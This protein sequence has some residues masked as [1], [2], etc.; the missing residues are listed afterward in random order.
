MSNDAA[1]VFSNDNSLSTSFNQIADAELTNFSGCYLLNSLNPKCKGQTYIGFT[2]NL[3]RRIQQHN[4]GKQFG[5]AKRT[6]G[7]GPW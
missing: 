1:I 2:V 4:K 3:N 5:G 7:R 6:N